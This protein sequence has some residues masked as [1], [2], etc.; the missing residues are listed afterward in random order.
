M[1][2]DGWFLAVKRSDWDEEF[3]DLVPADIDL[4]VATVL[5]VEAVYGYE[6]DNLIDYE[7]FGQYLGYEATPEQVERRKDA[8]AW[9][10][11]NAE[12]HMVW[13]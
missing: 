9:F 10:R 13:T 11:A 4:Y 7:S 1:G 6:G 3:P 12:K 8:V 2:A 5:G